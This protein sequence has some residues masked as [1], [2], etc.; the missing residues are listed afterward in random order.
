MEKSIT[1][2]ILGRD[3]TLRVNPEDEASMKDIA[4]YVD[5]RMQGFSASF[6]DQ[7][8]ITTAV[9]SALSIAEELYSVRERSVRAT[10]Q[11]DSLLD[12]LTAQLGEA[13]PPPPKARKPARKTTR[14]RTAKKSK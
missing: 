11:N 10:E 12:E 1:V 13:L 3:Y 7:P 8:P 6:P 2:R 14:K 5:E 4:R 9:I